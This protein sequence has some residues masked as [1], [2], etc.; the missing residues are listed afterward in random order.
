M[1]AVTE[2]VPLSPPMVSITCTGCLVPA[3][4]APLA[5]A[6]NA[7]RKVPVRLISAS[8][9]TPSRTPWKVK[10]P[11]SSSPSCSPSCFFKEPGGMVMEKVPIWS[12]TGSV[13]GLI[14]GAVL[15]KD[16]HRRWHDGH[17]NGRE[18]HP[19]RGLHR[20][21]G[22]V[23]HRNVVGEC[24]RNIDVLP[25]RGDCDPYGLIPHCDRGRHRVGGRGDHRN[26][27]GGG[28]GLIRDIGMFPIRGYGDPEGSTP[29][30]DR[31]RLHHV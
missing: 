29:H 28:K 7:Y 2:V 30:A 15:L 16:T 25:V 27:S 23:D 24:T 31:R 20:V 17:G 18:P 11:P 10:D 13:T 6:S 22:R 14:P 4:L 21:V 12:V 3:K 9:R 1:S 26:G 8:S 5:S 19:D